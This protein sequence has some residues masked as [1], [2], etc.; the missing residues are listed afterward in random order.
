MS[1][2]YNV[3]IHQKFYKPGDAIWVYFPY[4]NLGIE[5]KLSL[6]LRGPFLVL[7]RINGMLYQVGKHAKHKGDVI[8]HDI[9]ENISLHG[10]HMHNP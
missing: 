3:K 7:K 5:K 6:K 2:Y 9:W 1:R 10:S 4:Q 8:H